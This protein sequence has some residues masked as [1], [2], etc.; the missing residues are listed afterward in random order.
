[1]IIK[2]L[3]QFLTIHTAYPLIHNSQF[4]GVWIAPKTGESC[5][6]L[7]TGSDQPGAA[8]RPIR[9]AKKLILFF[10]TGYPHVS[11]ILST[12]YGPKQAESGKPCGRGVEKALKSSSVTGIEEA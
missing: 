2:T 9:N 3:R 11:A 1:L 6:P 5:P 12:G 8:V 4:N 10:S 7:S